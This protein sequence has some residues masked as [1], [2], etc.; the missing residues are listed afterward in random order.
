MKT[1]Q[2]PFFDIFSLDNSGPLQAPVQSQSLIQRYVDSSEF[3]QTQ[4]QI[5]RGEIAPDEAIIKM[6]RLIERGVTSSMTAFPVRENLD[7]EVVVLSPVDTPLRNMLPRVPGSGLAAKWKQQTAFGASLG[8]LTKTSGALNAANTLTVDNTR[9]FFVG[10][11]FLYLGTTFRITA[12]NHGTNVISVAAGI[13]LN[14]QLDD[15]A[16]LKVGFFWPEQGTAGRIF[17]KED[18]APESNTEVY[19]D[20]TASYKLLG[21][22]GSITMFAMAGGA[23][24]QAQY[25][26]AKRNCLMRALLK[27]EYAI[28]H[29]DDTVVA[30]PWGD[31]ATALAF[32]GMVP[33]IQATAPA[34]HLQ[35]SVG[36]L[37]VEHLQT[38]LARLWVKGG[39]RRYIVLNPQEALSLAKIAVTTGNYRAI[40]TVSEDGSTLG[41]RVT[42]IQAAVG[43]E[44]VPIYVHPFMPQGMILFGSLMNSWGQPGAEMDVLPQALGDTPQAAFTDGIQGFYAQDIAPTAAAPEVLNF[45][46]AIYELYK[47]KNGQIF[48]LSTG[49]TS[50]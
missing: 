11:D 48:A 30:A 23:N 2:P 12:I 8:T 32:K 38:Q 13:G 43:G 19:A 16:V 17:Y 7:A 41:V 1:L 25:P 31:G 34:D 29:G 6:Q 47:H 40:L 5:L 10:E 28:L 20:K 27:E 21:D 9:G 24:F 45:K 50:A 44:L 46:V 42:G 4:A 37:T 14:S 3:I 15:Q 18:G 26:I 39:R 33:S 49:V 35:T 36:A 22:M